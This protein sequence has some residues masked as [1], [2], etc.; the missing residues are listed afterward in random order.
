MDYTNSEGRR[1]YIYI[2]FDPSSG[3]V[4]TCD[5][6]DAELT[7]GNFTYNDIESLNSII[8]D[9]R[10]ELTSSYNPTSTPTYTNKSPYR[11]FIND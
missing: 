5:P 7:S 2:I 3:H 10:T 11:G 1:G 9:C 6:I 4:A 8:N